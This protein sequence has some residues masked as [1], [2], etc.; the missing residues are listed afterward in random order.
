[1]SSSESI[2]CSELKHILLL[3]C[4]WEGKALPGPKLT[5]ILARRLL[6]SVSL[7]SRIR[8]TDINSLRAG[9]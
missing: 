4:G 1:M 3:L 6:M 7:K 9:I 2:I 5:Y 8:L